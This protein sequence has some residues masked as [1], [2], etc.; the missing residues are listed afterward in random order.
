MYFTDIANEIK[1]EMRYWTNVEVIILD[2]KGN[3]KYSDIESERFLSSIS[4]FILKRGKKFA[5][6]DYYYIKNI[7]GVMLFKTSINSVV[8]LRTQK[9]VGILLFFMKI[10]EE[11]GIKID[12][13]LGILEKVGK[14]IPKMDDTKLISRK[15]PLFEIIAR[16][17]SPEWLNRLQE[18]YDKLNYL[19]RLRDDFSNF[20]IF[21]QVGSNRIFKCSFQGVIFDLRLSLQY[22]NVLPIADGFYFGKWFSPAGDHKNACL[23]I[24]KN[25]WRSDGRFGIAHFIQLLGFYTSIAN[26]IDI[27]VDLRP[28]KELDI[29]FY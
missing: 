22:P 19:Y 8:I 5:F 26:A 16:P 4:L 6:G 29:P 20:S 7:S 3:I 23:G 2:M 11:I 21:K 10:L 15:I 1:S 12:I 27:K 28:P 25:R 18:E 24:L 13:V 17:N 14:K 9:K